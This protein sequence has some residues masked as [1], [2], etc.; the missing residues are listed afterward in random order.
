MKVTI[1]NGAAHGLSRRD[2][3]A[4]VPELPASW[5]KHVKQIA[6]CQARGSELTTSYY[7]KEQILGLFWPLPEGAISKAE[8][9]R[10]LLLALS[11]VDERGQLPERLAT[12]VRQRHLLGVSEL[13]SLCLALV[14]EDG[15]NRS[16]GANTQ[17][18]CSGLP[19]H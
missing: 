17:R 3:E 16:G 19:K 4:V 9:L 5:A 6:L 1:Q 10:E 8:G 2:I 13:F 14:N 18:Q 11:V 15:S 12:S 7:P